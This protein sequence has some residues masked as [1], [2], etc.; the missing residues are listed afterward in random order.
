MKKRYFSF[1]GLLTKTKLVFSFEVFR[2]QNN[3]RSDLAT[4]PIKY[5]IGGFTIGW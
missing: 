1:A 2:L 3:C 4:F 5:V